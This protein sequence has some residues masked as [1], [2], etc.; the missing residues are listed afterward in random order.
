MWAQAQ[1]RC[2]GGDPDLGDIN[3][4]IMH[5]VG[6]DELDEGTR[7]HMKEADLKTRSRTFQHWNFVAVIMAH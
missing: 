4:G 3:M 5:S 7:A 1:H 2:P 6:S